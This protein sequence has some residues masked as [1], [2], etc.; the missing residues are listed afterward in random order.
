MEHQN[1]HI[2]S[3]VSEPQEFILDNCNLVFQVAFHC[4]CGDVL[5]TD[6]KQTSVENPTQAPGLLYICL[7][8]CVCVADW[9]AI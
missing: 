9:E 2:V 3:A 6:L 5:H 7:C 8:V 1:N 4:H